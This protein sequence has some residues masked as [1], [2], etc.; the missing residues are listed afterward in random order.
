MSSP[1]SA[2]RLDDSNATSGITFTSAARLAL[3]VGTLSSVVG[4]APAPLAEDSA[5]AGPRLV[6]PELAHPSSASASVASATRNVRRREVSRL[7]WQ[8]VFVVEFT[9]AR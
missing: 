2:L 6:A 1:P 4:P 3:C 5:V 8:P 7:L 9:A